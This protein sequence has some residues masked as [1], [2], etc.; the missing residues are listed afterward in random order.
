MPAARASASASASARVVLIAGGGGTVCAQGVD[1]LLTHVTALGFSSVIVVIDKTRVR[2]VT[3]GQLAAYVALLGLAQINP[4]EHEG[5]VPT[6]LQLFQGSGHPPQHLT[7][8]DRA[9]LYG[10]YNTNQAA[11]LQTQEINLSV[12]KAIER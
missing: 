4:E 11:T 8:W 5:T 10:L 2:G 9:L 1:T 6:I 7:A 12:L 3:Y